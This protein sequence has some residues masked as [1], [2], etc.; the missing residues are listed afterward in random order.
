MV[1]QRL[2]GFLMLLALVIVF[3]PIVFEPPST[4]PVL[5]LPEYDMPP[6][7][8]VESM[9]LTGSPIKPL[10]LDP[11]VPVREASRDSGVKLA[12]DPDLDLGGITPPGASDGPNLE[13]ASLVASRFGDNNMPMA[14]ELELALFSSESA[15]DRLATLLIDGGYKAYV[16]PAIQDDL[17][18]YSVRIGPKLQR[19]RLIDIKSRLDAVFG[20]ESAIRRFEP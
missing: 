13:D 2:L 20:I 18:F 14:W 12:V 7:P 5:V 4:E 3:W 1:R 15:A 11:R 17:S 8:N 6:K 19:E 10:D 9:D 16:A